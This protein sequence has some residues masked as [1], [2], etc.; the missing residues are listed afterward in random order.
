MVTVHGL[1]DAGEPTTCTSITN[2]HGVRQNF[3]HGNTWVD[4]GEKASSGALVGRFEHAVNLSGEEKTVA[5]V[6]RQTDAD[7]F[8][9]AKV[10][11]R[12]W[13]HSRELLFV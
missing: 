12:N 10:E 11:V 7:K 1:G 13:F 4:L 9:L 6:I 5:S 2:D 3:I 8:E